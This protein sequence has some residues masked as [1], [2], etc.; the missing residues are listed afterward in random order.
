MCHSPG[1]TRVAID[2][3]AIHDDEKTIT[4]RNTGMYVLFLGRPNLLIK[5]FPTV[6]RTR[7]AAEED[8]DDDAD[9]STH[10]SV[11]HRRHTVEVRQV[12]TTTPPR[13]H[14]HVTTS[15]YITSRTLH[16]TS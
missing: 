15:T 12:K 8:C 3:T 2:F 6:I 9:R 16:A 10:C 13:T 7:H 14:Y 5:W 4:I 11:H 1:G